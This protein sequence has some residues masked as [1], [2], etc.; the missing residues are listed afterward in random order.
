[1]SKTVENSYD[2]YSGPR[3]RRLRVGDR[4]R[5]AVAEVLRREHVNGRID[6]VEFQERLERSLTAKTYADLDALVADLPGER[7]PRRRRGPAWTP[8]PWPLA[9]VPLLVVAIV[10]SGGRVLWLAFPLFFFFV[11]RPLAWR[12]WG[13]GY[14]GHGRW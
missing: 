5:E 2:R 9:I 12:S 3:D 11:V 7:A 14:R 13:R 10:A 1:M 8:R 6:A 4:E